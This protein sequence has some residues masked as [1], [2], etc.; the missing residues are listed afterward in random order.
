MLLQPRKFR[1]KNRLKRRTCLRWK[2]HN[3]SYG[4]AGLLNLKPFRLTGKRIFNLKIFLKKAI[5]RSDKTRRLV[6]FN[7][8]PHLPLSKK[9]KG[10]RMG[11][12]VGKLYAWSSQ[13]AG[14]I[15]I[16]EFKNLRHGRVKYFFKQ[17]A[18]RLPTQ[19]KNV[20]KVGGSMCVTS[21]PTKSCKF[22]VLR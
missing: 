10:M 8:F 21:S 14:G 5:K 11:K 3:L 6:W 4:D 9:S 12:G 17:L 1:Y 2:N 7:V 20:F 22:T 19:T 15:N 13:L 18:H 16:L